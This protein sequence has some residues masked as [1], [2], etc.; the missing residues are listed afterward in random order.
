MMMMVV[1]DDEMDS[2]L[3]FEENDGVSW[4]VDHCLW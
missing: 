4:N 1:V 3:M 2:A